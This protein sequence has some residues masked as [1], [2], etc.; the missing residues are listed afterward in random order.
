MRLSEKVDEVLADLGYC[1]LAAIEE[2]AASD[3]ALAI[4]TDCAEVEEILKNLAERDSRDFGV[5][6]EN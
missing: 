3:I 2:H 6:D 5:C 1:A 4:G